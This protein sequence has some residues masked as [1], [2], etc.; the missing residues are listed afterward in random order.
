MSGFLE[1]ISMSSG[2]PI[3]TVLSSFKVV[4]LS[5]KDVYIEGSLSISSY[6]KEEV[7]IK[8]KGGFIIIMGENMVIK[9]YNKSEVRI[10]GKIKGI[11]CL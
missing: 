7:C 9:E 6:K 3:E 5:N 1:T 8:V 11:N 4:M 10:Y 2:L